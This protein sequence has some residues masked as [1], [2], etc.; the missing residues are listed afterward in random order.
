MPRVPDLRPRIGT[1]EAGVVVLV[2]ILVGGTCVQLSHRTFLLSHPKGGLN[3]Y[4]R[5]YSCY[6]PRSA[7]RGSPRA[8]RSA[9]RSPPFAVTSA[10]T[11]L[12]GQPSP[13][14]PVMLKEGVLPFIG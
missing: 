5:Y 1:L 7:T 4:D 12:C 13:I 14:F 11:G 10:S 8:G 6:W 2:P 3:L 9:I